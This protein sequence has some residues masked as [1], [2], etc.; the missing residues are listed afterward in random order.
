MRPARSQVTLTRPPGV[1]DGTKVLC[2][3]VNQP[4]PPAV[5]RILK[6]LANRARTRG[7]Q[8]SSER[9]AIRGTKENLPP[10]RG[11][12]L[13]GHRTLKAKN[14]VQP[15]VRSYSASSMP[16]SFCAGDGSLPNARSMQRFDM[17]LERELNTLYDWTNERVEQVAIREPGASQG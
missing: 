12:L 7:G 15:G 11:G 1:A 10:L 17:Q 8:S 9:S 13:P 5:L 3:A 2:E 6:V 4:R 16:A 14:G